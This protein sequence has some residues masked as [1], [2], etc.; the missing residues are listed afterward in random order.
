MLLSTS[1][2]CLFASRALVALRAGSA[3]DL[4]DPV[5][6]LAAIGSTAGLPTL[7]EPELEAVD[8]SAASS[9]AATGG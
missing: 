5:A 4:A 8:G 6:G 3:A 2:F 7:E 1:V 9:S